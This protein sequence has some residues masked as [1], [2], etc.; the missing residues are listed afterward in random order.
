MHI[1]LRILKYVKPY[2]IH[3]ISSLICILFFTLFSSATLVSVIPFLPIIFYENPLHSEDESVPSNDNQV[4]APNWENVLSNDTQIVS[5][6][7]Y[8]SQTKK[9]IEDYSR[10]SI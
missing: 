10:G 5:E 2:T 7:S 9:K 6:S 1:F 4:N 3:L 8:F